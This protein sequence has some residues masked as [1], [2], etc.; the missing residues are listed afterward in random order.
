MANRNP[1]ENSEIIPKDFFSF[2]N[3]KLEM[4]HI[5]QE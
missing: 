4:T 5:N 2:P 1:A 3:F